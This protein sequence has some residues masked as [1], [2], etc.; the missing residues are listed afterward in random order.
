MLEYMV[1]R[2]KL[3]KLVDQIIIATTDAREDDAIEEI[4]QKKGIQCFRGE[5]DN[6]LKRYSDASEEASY[7]TIVRLTGDCPLIDPALIDYVLREYFSSSAEYASN[8]MPESFPDGQDIE[9]FSKNL[10]KKAD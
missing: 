3:A 2:I 8:T 4:C 1:N 9:V 6:V 7:E 5:T 10:L